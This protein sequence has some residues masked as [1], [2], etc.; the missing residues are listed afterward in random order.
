M[1]RKLKNINGKRDTFIGQFDRYGGKSH[2]G[3]DEETLLLK[4]IKNISGDLLAEHLWFN[5]TKGFE[6]LGVLRAGAVVSFMA[7]VRSYKNSNGKINYK[8]IYPTK[9]KKIK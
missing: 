2:K 9:V 7:R 1:R 4:N 6:E 3:Y 8:L 5:V